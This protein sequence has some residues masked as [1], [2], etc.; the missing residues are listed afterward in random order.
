MSATASCFNSRP[1]ER[2][3]IH[4]ITSLEMI[5]EFQFT[6]LREGRLSIIMG[7]SP[8]I[9]FNSRPCER[10][11]KNSPNYDL[12]S[13]KFQFT[14]LRE[15]RLLSGPSPRFTGA[16]FNSRPCERGDFNSGK[17]WNYVFVVSI[18]APARG[19]TPIV[20]IMDNVYYE[21][22]FTPLREGRLF[23]VLLY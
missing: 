4:D 22:Q 8:N 5:N 15:G 6:P 21:F 20:P 7:V 2:G 19:A 10:G 11:D 14:P 12:K 1:C 17:R 18:H 9:C 16:G 23:I 13:G 3:D